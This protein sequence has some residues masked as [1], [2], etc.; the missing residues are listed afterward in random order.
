MTSRRRR[1]GR[2]PHTILN[3]QGDCKR[4]GTNTQEKD[5]KFIWRLNRARRFQSGRYL[6][7]HASSLTCNGE[8]RKEMWSRQNW[9]LHCE[10]AAIPVCALELSAY[11]TSIGGS[12]RT[13]VYSPQGRSTPTICGAYP[14]HISHDP[15]LALLNKD[16]RTF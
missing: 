2:S 10:I 3:A 5:K 8:R 6:D 13:Y 1:K 7:V 4:G 9:P 12:G 16:L 14:H 11:L 15:L